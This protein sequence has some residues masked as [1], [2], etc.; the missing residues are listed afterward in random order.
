MNR[1]PAQGA[2]DEASANAAEKKNEE[3]LGTLQ[4]KLSSLKSVTISINEEVH[5]QNKAL[6]M[7]QSG[8]GATDNLLG[9]TLKRVGQMWASGSSSSVTTMATGMVVAFFLC[10]YLARWLLRE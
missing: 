4:S 3:L 10:F 9:S 1:R 5:E 6:E 2:A 7:M 8:M